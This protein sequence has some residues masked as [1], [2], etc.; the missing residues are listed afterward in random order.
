[1]FS[2]TTICCMLH[3]KDAHMCWEFNRK[4]FERICHLRTHMC[5]QTHS[6][7]VLSV[8]MFFVERNAYL[9]SM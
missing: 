9:A 2:F 7:C 3:V 4:F 1:M 5:V 6:L 8:A